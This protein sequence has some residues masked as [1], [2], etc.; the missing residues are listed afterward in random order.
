MDISTGGPPIVIINIKDAMMLDLHREDRLRIKKGGREAVVIVDIG[1]SSR[2]V[3]QGTIGLFEEALA[4]I[5]A[6]HNDVVEVFFENKP[7]SI[8]YIKEKLEGRKLNNPKIVQIVKDLVADRL[9][10]IEITYFVSACYTN[11]L[12]EEE[13][14]SLTMAM[15]ET[16]QSLNLRKHKVF[17]KHSIGGIAGNRTTMIIVPIVCSAGITM[18]KTSS[19]SITSPAGTADTM[20]VLADVSLSIGRMKKVIEKTSGCIVWG[21]ALKLAP[22]DDKIIKVEN[23]LSVDAEGQLLASIM[24]KKKSVSS[25]HVIIDIPIGR[26]AKV[27]DDKSANKLKRAFE[28]LGKHI[29]IKTKVII[30]DGSQPIGNGIGPA[31]EA[32]DVLWVLERNPMRPLDLEKKAV[33]MAGLIFEMAGKSKKGHGEKDAMQM[34][35]SGKAHA[36]MIEIINAQG[37]HCKYPGRIKIGRFRYDVL[38][39]KNGKIAEVSNFVISKI[40]RIAGAPKNKGAGIYLHKHAGDFVE[41][42]EKLFTI[43]SESRQKLKFAVETMKS[44]SVVKI[45]KTRCSELSAG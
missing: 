33:M 31:L 7:I 22:A 45:T 30:T 44:L 32:R 25:T 2:A 21:G 40:A 9:S 19:R 39:G 36:K 38:A 42:N 8:Q 4:K 14:K 10:E 12:D 28:I 24:A 34:L 6:R 17:D 13:T 43:Y 1:E 26:E 20:E 37:I 23:P 29:G 11:G 15:A 5:N 18:P 41:K 27:S 35:D 16:G 3:K